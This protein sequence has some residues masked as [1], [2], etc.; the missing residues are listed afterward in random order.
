VLLIAVRCPSVQ[1][2]VLLISLLV[3]AFPVLLRSGLQCAPKCVGGFSLCSLGSEFC[4]RVS[5]RPEFHLALEACRWSL[6]RRIRCLVLFC[7]L[8]ASV[9]S[10]I[11]SLCRPGSSSLSLHDLVSRPRVCLLCISSAWSLCRPNPMA[12]S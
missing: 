6:F 8:V 4:C 9:E 7:F 5:H 10:V 12:H 11:A 1:S 3:S 2:P